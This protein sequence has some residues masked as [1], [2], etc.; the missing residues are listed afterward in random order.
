MALIAALVFGAGLSAT[1]FAFMLAY[2]PGI[3]LALSAGG[4]A[5]VGLRRRP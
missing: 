5:A 3:A 1:L 2:R 4:D